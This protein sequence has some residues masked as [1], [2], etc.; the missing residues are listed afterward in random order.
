MFHDQHVSHKWHV[1]AI[2]FFFMPCPGPAVGISSVGSTL[3]GSSLHPLTFVHPHMFVHPLY[4]QMPPYVQTQPVCAWC[5]P[6]HLYVLGGICMWYGDGGPNMFVQSHTLR[7]PLL[8]L[9]APYVP[10][11]PM[12]MLY[13]PLYI[14]LCLGVSACD[15]GDKPHMLGSG[16][17][18]HICQAFWCLVSTSIVLSL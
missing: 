12:A 9:D 6:V 3:S 11:P 10:T 18:Q 2:L 17:H 16:G 8:H 13:V 5:S 7:C 14:Y 1:F 15:M 4:V